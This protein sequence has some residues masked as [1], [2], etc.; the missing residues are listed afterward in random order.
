M[1]HINCSSRIKRKLQALFFVVLLVGG[2][3]AIC[4]YLWFRWVELD[5]PPV[6][7]AAAEAAIVPFSGFGTKSGVDSETHRRLSATLSLYW[8]KRIRYVVCVGGARPSMGLSGSGRMKEVLLSAGIPEAAIILDLQ[9]NDTISNME[10]ALRILKEQNLDSAVVVSSA[11]QLYRIR[12]ILAG[13]G[14]S[15][16]IDLAPYDYS[17]CNPRV[18]W[19]ELWLQIHHE[20]IARGGLRPA[21]SP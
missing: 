13:S 11:L 14:F 18:T 4:G 3:D 16:R 5:A 10:Q 21:A 1:S 15:G 17:S 8:D 6:R 20:W 12:R 9:S 19:P 7:N 2:V